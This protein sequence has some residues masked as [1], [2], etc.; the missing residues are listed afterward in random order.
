[1]SSTTKRTIAS[2]KSISAKRKLGAAPMKSA[3]RR[4]NAVIRRLAKN[5]GF[6]AKAKAACCPNCGL[7]DVSESFPGHD[8]EDYC[9][10]HGQGHDQTFNRYG[11]M[12]ED[13]WL[14]W[15]GDVA[16]IMTEFYDAGFDVEW[17][18]NLGRCVCVK[19]Q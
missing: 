13:L 2:T 9:F 5:H 14:N 18:G 16:T 4:I 1:M 6:A 17:N 12:I 11:E 10:Y 7:R 3:R 8:L 19:K 15:G